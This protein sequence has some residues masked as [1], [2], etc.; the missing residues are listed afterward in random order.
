MNN[1]NRSTTYQKALLIILLIV[2][3]C[4]CEK[5]KNKVLIGENP[6]EFN[7]S[8]TDSAVY[9]IELIKDKCISP[10]IDRT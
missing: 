8:K 4:S 6:Q 5:N 2:I 10:L 3:F 7:I 9:T 1:T